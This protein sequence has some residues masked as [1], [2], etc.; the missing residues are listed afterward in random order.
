MDINGQ[1][2][3]CDMQV[4]LYVCVCHKKRDK[5]ELPARNSTQSD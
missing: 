1:A 5:K 4:C 3:F 2:R